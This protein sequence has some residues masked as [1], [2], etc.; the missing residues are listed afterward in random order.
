M[1]ICE[2]T[3]IDPLYYRVLYKFKCD[4]N[5]KKLE[6]TFKV[7][8]GR[9]SIEIE[10]FS[11]EACDYEKLPFD[12]FLVKYKFI[13]CLFYSIFIIMLANRE[14]LLSYTVANIYGMILLCYIILFKFLLYKITIILPLIISI[15]IGLATSYFFKQKFPVFNNT[16][17]FSI[18][19]FIFGDIVVEVIFIYFKLMSDLEIWA[20]IFISVA[21]FNLFNFTNFNNSYIVCTSFLFAFFTSN[22][23]IIGLSKK[24]PMGTIVNSLVEEGFEFSMMKKFVYDKYY[25]YFIIFLVILIINILIRILICK[26]QNKNS[27]NIIE[28][29]PLTGIQD[30]AA[31]SIIKNDSINPSDNLFNISNN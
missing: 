19:G 2:E 8:T 11:K 1:D 22:I 4:Y 7:S 13:V 17:F 23:Y 5:L 9:C 14:I 6:P 31:K 26:E 20:I 27:E 21:T 3:K 28:M 25:I 29:I 18:T 24:V 16:V 10:I 15:L 30:R 12:S